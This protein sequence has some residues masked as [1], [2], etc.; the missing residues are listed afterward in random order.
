ML[1]PLIRTVT[2]NW[3]YW[4]VATYV[5]KVMLRELSLK[6]SFYPFLSGALLLDLTNPSSKRFFEQPGTE[7]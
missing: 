3:F 2:V 5:L 4:W 1:W 7:F 6:Y